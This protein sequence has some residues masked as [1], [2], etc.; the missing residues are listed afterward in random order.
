MALTVVVED[1]SGLSNANAFASVAE[2]TAI[3]DEDIYA[4]AWPA[5]LNDQQSAVA[6]RATRLIVEDVALR[7]WRWWG[8]PISSLQALPFPRAGLFD[9]EG[10]PIASTI[11]PT[12]IKR[13]VAE[14]C[15]IIAGVDRAAA[16]NGPAEQS[17]TM[18]RTSVTYALPSGGSTA[19][20]VPNRLYSSILHLVDRVVIAVR[21]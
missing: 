19:P 13:L 15:E 21:A 4:A 20:V 9:R 1:G 6:V 3:L 7:G 11:V 12:D 2:I 5:L 16:A 18:G 10:Y 17:V 14:F 8:Y